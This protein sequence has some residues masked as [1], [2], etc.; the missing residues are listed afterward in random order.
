MITILHGDDVAASRDHYY[1]LKS[2]QESVTFD[3]GQI[4]TDLLTSS[5]SGTDLFGKTPTVFIENLFSQKKIDDELISLLNHKQKDADIVLWEKKEL[6]K[7]DLG[8]LPHAKQ[9][10]FKLPR[11]IFQFLDSLGSNPEQTIKLF[12]QTAENTAVEIIFSMLSKRI[13]TLLFLAEPGS[14]AIEEVEKLADWQK[15]RLQKQLQ[16]FTKERLLKAQKQLFK[17]ELSTKTG[18]AV[19]P[20]KASLDYFLL[21]L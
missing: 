2:K 13:R 10:P 19:F 6:F 3:A 7:K 8:L 9:I 4:D 15:S 14:H 20:L 5:L 12:S 17:I 16:H 21:D 18:Q 1:T 11:S